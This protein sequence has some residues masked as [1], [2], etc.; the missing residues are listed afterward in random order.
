MTNDEVKRNLK[1]LKTKGIEKLICQ[2]VIYLHEVQMLEPPV[3]VEEYARVTEEVIRVLSSRLQPI[4]KKKER[5]VQVDLEELIERV[6]REDIEQYI[7]QF[8]IYIP[9]NYKMRFGDWEK[10][11]EKVETL[12]NEIELLEKQLGL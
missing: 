7:R 8:E 9:E 3:E 5:V 4:V 6:K 10:F 1:L 12:F 11:Q 2:I